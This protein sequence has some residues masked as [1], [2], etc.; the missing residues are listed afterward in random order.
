MKKVLSWGLITIFTLASILALVSLDN[1]QLISGV[2]NFK[3]VLIFAIIMTYMT[4]SAFPTK[5]LLNDYIKNIKL[6]P[7]DKGIR[8]ERGTTGD[9]AECG[10]CG[11]D[12]CLRKILQYN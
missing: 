11:D 6:P 2:K 7:G 3:I 8:G 9:M 5:V 10:S 4:L 12:L 1:I